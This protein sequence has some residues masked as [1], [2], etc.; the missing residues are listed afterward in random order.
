MLFLVVP[1]FSISY[2][3]LSCF[4]LQVALS[5]FHKYFLLLFS[6][7]AFSV[8]VTYSVC[9]FSNTNYT[10]VTFA[11]SALH[12]LMYHSPHGSFY[13]CPFPLHSLNQVEGLLPEPVSSSLT[14]AL[15][16]VTAVGALN[17][18]CPSCPLFLSWTSHS[19][20]Y[21]N[22]SR[23]KNELNFESKRTCEWF[24]SACEYFLTGQGK[25]P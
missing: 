18:Y 11:S 8:L 6:E 16:Y 10:Y 3:P 15:E 25:I 5:L 2:E 12:I 1:Y 21:R 23:K 19:G 4:N 7:T 20:F 13:L 22:E 14:V 9:I 24:Y 17:R